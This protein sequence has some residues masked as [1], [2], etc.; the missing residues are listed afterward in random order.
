VGA[1]T[2][3]PPGPAVEPET[4]PAGGVCPRC[5]TPY[6]PYQEYCLEC[7]LRLPLTRGVIPRL[8]A[9]W[10]R[11]LPW[12][13]GDWLW[14]VL[15]ALLISAAAAVVAIAV[16]G[17][18]D[19]VDR[20]V[21]TTDI[22]IV[23]TTPVPTQPTTTMLPTGPAITI[24][25]NPPTTP[26]GTATTPVPTQPATTVPAKPAGPRAWPA[27]RNGYTIVLASL[28]AA[29]GRAGATRKAKDALEA[30]LGDVGV[31]DSKDFS[32]L[33]PG[34]YVVFTGIYPSLGAAQSAMGSVR[35][36]GFPQAYPRQIT[37]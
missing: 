9:A 3:E 27:G 16:T 28:P 31:I 33:H 32:S 5:A 20:R 12:Y 23:P 34:Y 18:D 1:V 7:G 37:H 36:A 21:A 13:P 6:E 4:A 2:P 30:G 35:A 14:P 15:L 26:P 24:S 25:P 10:T 11:R 29:G 17:R 22:G 8:H 19:G